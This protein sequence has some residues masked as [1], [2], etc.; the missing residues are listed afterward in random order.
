MTQEN[1]NFQ[2]IIGLLQN[3][4][5]W[6]PFLTATDIHSSC[7]ID[8]QI[9]QST[10]QET[11]FTILS[12][13]YFL[14]YEL[15][16]ISHSLFLNYDKFIDSYKQEQYL[17]HQNI[18]TDHTKSIL[19]N[20]V[21]PISEYNKTII[22]QINTNMSA[23]TSYNSTN[24]SIFEFEDTS[25]IIKLKKNN[26]VNKKSHEYYEL[27]L[28]FYRMYEYPI[29]CITLDVI[30]YDVNNKRIK[31]QFQNNYNISKLAK[32][33]LPYNIQLV[34]Q[35]TVNNDNYWINIPIIFIKLPSNTAEFNKIENV[36]KNTL[37]YI[38]KTHKL[39]DKIKLKDISVIEPYQYATYNI[40]KPIN[41]D[42]L[43][44]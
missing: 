15:T 33:L 41:I 19:I 12:Q 21:A 8:K 36:I 13:S 14:E 24:N 23:T 43:K 5:I 42:V 3:A 26:S 4:L 9:A 30:G 39:S 2:K 6:K 11:D 29:I 37:K 28:M 27:L 20:T 1:S 18:S 10:T 32:N 40:G 7:I 35:P 25:S 44:I 16:P 22:G 38:F 17:F 31:L 34:G